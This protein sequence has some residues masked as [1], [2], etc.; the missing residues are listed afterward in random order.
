MG[1]FNLI[2]PNEATGKAKALLDKVQEK[3]G[4]I[5]NI[6]KG[7]ANAPQ[8]LEG[9][10][11]FSAALA[12]G[13]L[14]AKLRE[15]LSLAVAESNGCDYCLAAHTAI[16]RMVGLSEQEVEDARLASAVDSSDEA[17]LQFAR[18]LVE[19]RGHASDADVQH[20]RQAGFD[21]GQ[22]I[23]IVASVALNTFT[24]YFNDV[25]MTE[26]DFPAAAKLPDATV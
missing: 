12:K 4:M 23:E 11:G 9:Y 2:D 13:T 7:M 16:A 15:R 20:L 25:A 3:L 8:A 22:I 6:A 18:K 17:A 24:N 10:L 19:D 1:R 5:P 26:V 14:S 21:D